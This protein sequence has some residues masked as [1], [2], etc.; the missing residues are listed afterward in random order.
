MMNSEVNKRISLNI[1]ALYG[2]DHLAH[3]EFIYFYLNTKMNLKEDQ[4]LIETKKLLVA[5]KHHKP[6]IVKCVTFCYQNYQERKH[7]ENKHRLALYILLQHFPESWGSICNNAYTLLIELLHAIVDDNLAPVLI[8]PQ[9]WTRNIFRL[10]NV[11][12]PE[13]VKGVLFGIDP[14]PYTTPGCSYTGHAFCFDCFDDVEIDHNQSKHVIGLR[15]AYYLSKHISFI[16]PAMFEEQFVRKYGLALINFI[17]M[18]P[19]GSKAGTGNRFHLLWAK[20][21]CTWLK[22]G[23]GI[24]TNDDALKRVIIFENQLYPFDK[25]K[26]CGDE[27]AK[28]LSCARRHSYQRERMGHCINKPNTLHDAGIIYFREFMIRHDAADAFHCLCKLCIL[29]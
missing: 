10:E 15:E 12:R 4:I 11:L 7:L 2:E 23:L 18:I 25:Y 9:C 5:E 29:L 17:R 1:T 14:L 24:H 26:Y 6:Q 28:L 8:F 20:Y 19:E 3:D 16:N 13:Q 22:Q 27:A 21:H